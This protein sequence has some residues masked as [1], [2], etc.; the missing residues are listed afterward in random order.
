VTGGNETLNG[1]AI[2]MSLLRNLTICSNQSNIRYT[3]LIA[4]QIDNSTLHRRTRLEPYK[5]H[6]S[7]QMARVY[8]EMAKAPHHCSCSGS[9]GNGRT[10]LCFTIVT[11]GSTRKR[12]GERRDCHGHLGTWVVYCVQERDKETR[13]RHD[14]EKRNGATQFRVLPFIPLFSL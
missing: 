8:R 4:R 10:D 3:S 12:L 11:H 9:K 14:R 7:V 2:I 1:D 6:K 13:K 5:S